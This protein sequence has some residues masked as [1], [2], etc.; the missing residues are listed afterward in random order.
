MYTYIIKRLLLLFPMLI[1]ITFISFLVMQ[2]APGG[3]GTGG[4]GGELAAGKLTKDQRDAMNRAFHLDKPIHLRYL[5]WLGVI[6][7]KPTQEELAAAKEGKPIP[8]RGI[9]FGDFGPSME[10]RSI[11]VWQRLRE[12]IPVTILLNVISFTVI[13]V[14][15]IPIGVY[16]ATHQ[17]SLIDRT[18]T[19]GLFMLFSLPSMFVG[20]MLIKWMVSLPPEYRLPFQGVEPANRDE[21][22]TLQWLW[23][24]I[25]HLILPVITMSYAG[26]SVISRYMRASMIDVI[27]ADYIRT[28]R[29]KGL[30]ETLVV[31][32]H[33]LRNSLIPII[34]LLGGLL[35]SLIGGSVIIE[36]I[37]GVP[38]M[39]KLGYQAL[40]ARDYTVLMADITI[41]AILVMLGFLISDLLYLAADPRI[42]FDEK[43]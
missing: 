34:T 31:Y 33:A 12:A 19:V 27:R 38:G 6:Q 43:G 7:P 37:F 42:S 3:A 24:S 10:T 26:L 32:K 15:A 40:L 1:G 5:Y 25:R 36:A 9:I 41:I 13:Y 39:G 23:G 29:A 18:S 17:N 22:T 20:I 16:S 14:L 30:P 28:A 2:L 8:W 21:L 11:P 35:P 4:G